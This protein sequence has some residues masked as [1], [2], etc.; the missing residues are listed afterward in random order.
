[1]GGARRISRRAPH[2]P[3]AMKSLPAAVL[4]WG[5]RS[6]IL[7]VE[8]PPHRRVPGYRNF[9]RPKF[10][11]QGRVPLGGAQ[12]VGR[13]AAFADLGLGMGEVVVDDFSGGNTFRYHQEV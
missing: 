4:T 6:R 11:M 10:L 2:F 8:S 12:R 13:P 5:S 3:S 7:R 9:G 1:M